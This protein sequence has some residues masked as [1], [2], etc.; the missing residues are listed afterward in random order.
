MRNELNIGNTRLVQLKNL[1]KAYNV[2]S[3]IFAKLE[4]ENPAGSIKDRVALQMILDYEANGVI[5]KDTTII[6]PTSGNTGIGLAYVCKQRGYKAVI[7]M[8]DNMSRERIDLIESYG[9]SVELTDGALGMMGAINKANEIKALTPNSVIAGQFD[10][11]SNPRAHFLTTGPEIY[12]QMCGSIDVL[13]CGVG[14]GGTITGISDYLRHKAINVEVVAIEPENSAV[15]SGGKAGPHGIQGIGAGFIPS[16]LDTDAYNQIITVTDEQAY[17]M[18]R[19]VYEKEGIMVGISSGA[20]LYGAIEMAKSREDK[21][22]VVILP[23]TGTR[24]LSLGL[25]DK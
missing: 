21:N 12:R 16:V 22:I 25:F 4:N 6:E 23:D 17:K 3:R 5:N 2:K 19:E 20:A 10:N 8:P 7:V 24:Y 11:P 18:V 14:T 13:V 15:L 9:A 1:A